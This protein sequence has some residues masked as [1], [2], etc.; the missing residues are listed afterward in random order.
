MDVESHRRAMALVDESRLLE[1]AGKHEAAREKLE[2]AAG[3]EEACADAAGNEKPRTRG[4]LRVSAVSL[5]LSSGRLERAELVARRY[6]TEPLL[7][8]FHR[9]LSAIL[10]QTVE[11]RATL[12]G[13]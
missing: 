1:L 5:W 12:R 3:L 6:L 4:I 9:E 10:S 7:P 13:T 8:G 2:Q 11:R